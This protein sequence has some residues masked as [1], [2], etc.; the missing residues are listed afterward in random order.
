MTSFTGQVPS[1][2]RCHLFSWSG[3]FRGVRGGEKTHR[4]ER[5]L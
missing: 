3:G 1:C 2:L 4:V 5:V